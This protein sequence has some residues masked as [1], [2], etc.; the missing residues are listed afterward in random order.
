MNVAVILDYFKYFIPFSFLE[1]ENK[2][3]YVTQRHRF[4]SLGIKNLIKFSYNS[5]KRI[6]SD[7]LI[8]YSDYYFK[9]TQLLQAISSKVG[10][11]H[12][13][14]AYEDFYQRYFEKN[15][16]ELLLS[17]GVT[18]FE[19]CGLFIA[20]KLGIK[21]L[22]VW[23][24][25]FRPSTISYDPLGMNVESK[26][27]SKL[28]SEIE[29]HIPSKRF[30]D[31]YHYYSSNAERNP[32]KKTKLKDIQKDKFDFLHQ[33]R[34]R[35]LDRSD[36][37]RIRLPIRD[38]LTARISYFTYKN[39]YLRISEIHE[40]FIFFPLQTHT[41][42]NIV[43]NSMLFPYEKYAELVQ[44][45]FLEIQKKVK[46]NLIIKEHPFDVLRKKY[47]RKESSH[48]KWLDPTVSTD[49]VLNHELCVGTILVNST[50]GLESLIFG[51]PVL[52]MGKAIYSRPELALNLE[53]HSKE[54]FNQKIISLI[55]NK[56]DVKAVKIFCACLF[57]TMQ[58][59]GNIDEEPELS[60]ILRFEDLFKKIS[61]R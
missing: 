49:E 55:A 31:F 9:A 51:K 32:S 43:I 39:K 56:V 57:D 58:I 17:G 44:K 30:V 27:N 33:L 1:R 25:F 52:T 26:F 13:A 46:C 18:G 38:H 7:S 12:L 5:S 4:D 24:G 6:T 47:F 61:A 21:T 14:A 3:F 22:S 42:S 15:K 34:N 8:G 59:E 10:I 2:Y 35:F 19:R 29:S 54:E 37:E 11:I 16:I 60:E 28:W 50:A 48:I 40:P 45:Y 41:D 23:E 53:N 36:I 20:R